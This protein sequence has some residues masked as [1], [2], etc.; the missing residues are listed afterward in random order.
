MA[1]L[2]AAAVACLVTLAACDSA[3]PAPFTFPDACD[4][5]AAPDAACYAERRVP[6]SAEVALA[7]RVAGRWMDVHPAES[8]AWNWPEGVLLYALGELER[9][10][11]DARV[12]AYLRAYL[13]HHQAAGI[14]FTW[15]DSC[16]PVLAA[17]DLYAETGEARDAQVAHDFIAYVREFAHYTEPGGISHFGVLQLESMWLDS[18]FMVGMGLARWAEVGGDARALD[19]LGEQLRIFAD[20]LQNPDGLYTHAWGWPEASDPA[21]RWAR[22]NAWVTVAA[23]DYLRLRTLDHAD[24]AAVRADLAAQIAAVLATQDAATGLWHTVLDRGD[25]TYLETSASGLFAYALARGYRYGVFGD[26][27]LPAMHAAVAGVRA[28]LVDDEEGRP[29]VT[30]SSGPTIVGTFD[31]YAEVAQEDDLPYGVAAVILALVESSGLP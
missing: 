14:S 3:Q 31:D 29:V 16:P 20:V 4:A 11:G 30:G 7:L 10:T 25:A 26:E 23:V 8:L 18:L 12:H 28:R 1:N 6:D 9:V 27:V 22:G 19:E 17:I 24:D 2:R 13:D 15:S 5:H 21:V